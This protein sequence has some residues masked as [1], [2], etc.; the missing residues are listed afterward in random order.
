[1]HMCR[2][3]PFLGLCRTNEDAWEYLGTLGGVWVRLEILGDVWGRVGTLGDTWGRVGIHGIWSPPPP[4]TK[5]RATK[6]RRLAKGSCQFGS[7]SRI[8]LFSRYP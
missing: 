2:L 6:A 3:Q 7:L 1:M 8:N 5:S 4:Y